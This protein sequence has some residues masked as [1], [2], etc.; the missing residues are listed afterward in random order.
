MRFIWF[1]AVALSLTIISSPA[2]AQEAP[3]D[4]PGL[5]HGLA[6]AL[7]REKLER[8]ETLESRGTAA[9]VA[10]GILGGL[11]LISLFAGY[12]AHLSEDVEASAAPFGPISPNRAM[13]TPLLV[14]GAASATVGLA[15]AV[16]ANS[17]YGD[18]KDLRAE[19]R[20]LEVTVLPG[21]V[22]LGLAWSF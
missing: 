16:V 9:F 6:G 22:A 18:A 19:A 12:I 1:L 7:H 15:L 3:P 20:T 2:V 17:L 5:P 11:G 21:G 13:S 10:G 8:A 4:E 14:G